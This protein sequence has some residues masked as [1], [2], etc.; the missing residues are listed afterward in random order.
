MPPSSLDC[1]VHCQQHD[2]LWAGNLV[3]PPNGVPLVI[4]VEHARVDDNVEGPS[5]KL[6][7]L[8][9]VGEMKTEFIGD[10]VSYS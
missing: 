2:H 6:D 8:G 1:H 10:S 9:G 5:V 4:C 3:R 7:A